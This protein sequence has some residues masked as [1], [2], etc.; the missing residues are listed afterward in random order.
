MDLSTAAHQL[1]LAS[2]GMQLELSLEECHK[3]AVASV[4]RTS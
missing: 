2:K 1:T 4:D 3:T